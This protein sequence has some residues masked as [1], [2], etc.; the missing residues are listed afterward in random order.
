[1]VLM[2]ILEQAQAGQ[3][4]ATVGAATGLSAAEAKSAIAA[5]APAIAEALRNRASQDETAYDH[6]LDVLEDGG[7][8]FLDSPNAVQD[9][10]AIAD[11]NAILKDV[12]GSQA[13][14]LKTAKALAPGV[15]AG[16]LPKLTAISAC[17][18]LAALERGSRAPLGLMGS[19]PLA[20]EAGSSG[21]LLGSIVSA[22]IEG[23]VQGATRSLS[24]KASSRHRY[25]SRSRRKTTRRRTTRPSLESIFSE[26]LGLGRR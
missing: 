11:G 25:S 19:R 17:A 6:L 10:E 3:F 24:R 18:V 1:M 2:E 14:A 21:G 9:R 16:A 15:D 7:D 26:L 20:G 23:V 5:L 12:F 8:D 4:F 22:V 13:K